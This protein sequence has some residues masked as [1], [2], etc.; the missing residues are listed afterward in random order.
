M[1]QSRWKRRHGA[2]R[3]AL[4]G[5]LAMGASG[6]GCGGRDAVWDT[7][8]SRPLTVRRLTTAA[9]VIDAQTERVVT[10]SVGPDEDGAAL[11]LGVGSLPIGRG[12]ATSLV[13]PDA[14]RLLVLSRGDVPRRTADDQAPSLTVI[15]AEPSPAIG[16]RYTLSDALSGLAVDPEGRYA[17]V[18]PSA[19]DTDSFLQNPN[20]LLIVDLA[21]EPTADNP[22]PITLRS[23]GGRPQGFTFTPTL[24]VP[25][26]ARRLLVVQ[27]DRDIALVDF[28]ALDLPE[29]TIPLTGGPDALVPAGLAVSDGDPDRDDDARIAIRAANDP[30][31]VLV[32]LQPVP[33]N[34]RETT[35]QSFVAR[36]NIVFV[37][38]APSDLSFVQTDGGL[39]LAALV[40]SQSMMRLVD[41]ATGLGTAVALGAPFERISLV[42][43]VVG[44]TTK[45]SDVAL[46]WS[47]SSPDI[48]F[49]ALGSTVGT[50]YKAVDRLGLASPVTAVHD[51]ASPNEHLKVLATSDGGLVVLDMLERTASPITSSSSGVEV[52]TSPDGARAWIEAGG[53]DLAHLDLQS[54]HPA[55]LVL[56][57][58][59]SDV[60]DVA[61]SDGG[62]ALVVV[63]AVGTVGVTVLDAH[64]PSLATAREYSAVLLGG[65][66]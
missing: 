29:I 22:V 43:S 1:R 65:L 4:L 15:E 56:S 36:P 57:R 14:R 47:T 46:L 24:D 17:V 54:L 60:A 32:E 21:A 16:A 30:N 13:S 48:A 64:A 12:Y 66:R 39:R 44:E 55:N 52:V 49:V 61:T 40:P 35:P 34:E 33:D 19:A 62:R 2:G 51:V 7:T 45:G 18:Y 31:V 28:S 63:H 3:S 5:V 27:T 59:I 6:T 25:G 38:G 42:T 20:E 50:P 11:G 26:G 8:V 9:A 41:P 53:D 10:L 58:S 37:G 23:F